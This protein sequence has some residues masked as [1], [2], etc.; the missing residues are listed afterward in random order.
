MCSNV[1]IQE[2]TWDQCGDINYPKTAGV[3]FNRT[4]N[5]SIINC[6][7]QNFMPCISVEISHSTGDIKVINSKFM[8]NTVSNASLCGSSFYSSL[9]IYQTNATA[10]LISNSLF[11]YNGNSN[12]EGVTLNGSLLY[13]NLDE[14]L[15]SL[16]ILIKNTDFVFN[17]IRGLDFFD[18]AQTKVTLDAV[19][20]FNNNQGV[21]TY[22]CIVGEDITL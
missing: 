16:S 19:N 20:V 12:Q 15:A 17:G 11:F 8:F 7:F 3:I 21:Y 5:V 22:M 14:N 4:S 18:S 13:C 9:L 6:I 2:I 1:T 10:I